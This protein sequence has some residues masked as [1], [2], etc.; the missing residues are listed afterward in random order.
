MVTEL[1]D[2]NMQ[3]FLS[4]GSPMR[5]LGKPEEIVAMMLM[6]LSPANSYMTGQCIAIDGGV[7]AS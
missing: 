7:S 4:K 1:A 2:E 5:R 3:M 6:V